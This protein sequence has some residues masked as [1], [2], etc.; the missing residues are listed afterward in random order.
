MIYPLRESHCY[1]VFTLFLTY[2][3][4]FSERI[5]FF[6]INNNTVNI[7]VMICILPVFS[8]CVCFFLNFFKQ[9]RYTTFGKKCTIKISKGS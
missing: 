6:T 3:I 1:P 7:Y 9:I 5:F 4:N 2:S 8:L